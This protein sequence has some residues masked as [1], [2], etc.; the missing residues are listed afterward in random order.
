MKVPVG[1]RSRLRFVIPPRK[2]CSRLF[3]DMVPGSVVLGILVL[4]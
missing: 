4:E 3:L 1:S 2:A